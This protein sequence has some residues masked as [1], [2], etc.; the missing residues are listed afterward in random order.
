MKISFKCQVRLGALKGSA[1]TDGWMDVLDYCASLSTHN[2]LLTHY[3]A[4]QY[5]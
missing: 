3:I 5:T 4:L 2:C 1:G